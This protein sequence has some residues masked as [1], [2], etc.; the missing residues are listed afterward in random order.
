MN[1]L[2]KIIEVKKDEVRE[3][4]RKTSV[5][6]LEEMPL[7]NRNCN[8]LKKAISEKQIGIIAEF[9]QKSPSKGIINSNASIEEV[10]KGYV[11]AGAVGISVLTDSDFFGGCLENLVK[12][13]KANPDTPIL[14]KD[15]IIDEIQIYEAKAYGADV[16]LLIAACLKKEE[17][18]NLAETAKKLGLEI[19]VEVHNEDELEKIP[20]FNDLVGINNRNLKTFEVDI[21]HSIRLAKQIPYQ[22]IKISES[23]LSE[24]SNIQLLK[25]NGFKG[26]LIGETFMK[27]NDPAKTCREFIS[28][29]PF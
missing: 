12:T 13:R 11:D 20:D 21:Q 18:F 17:L 19:L 1:I 24:V 16:I 23:G 25:E 15:F 2:N 27:T 7:F 6:M 28:N 26:F 5:K 14:R 22:F 29:L 8:S 4:K 10:T 9:K 3:L